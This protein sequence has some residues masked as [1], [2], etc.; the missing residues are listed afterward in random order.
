MGDLEALQ[1]AYRGLAKSLD[2]ERQSLSESRA[3][4]VALVQELS[5]LRIRDKQA[6]DLS[7]EKQQLQEELA[8]LKYSHDNLKSEV[9]K[10]RRQANEQHSLLEHKSFEIE[11][12]RKQIDNIQQLRDRE[13]A[14]WT[15]E[16][17]KVE[18]EAVELR[19]RLDWFQTTEQAFRRMMSLC[20]HIQE[21]LKVAILSG[22]GPAHPLRNSPLPPTHGCAREQGAA[23]TRPT[24]RS[25]GSGATWSRRAQPCCTAPSPSTRA[26]TTRRRTTPSSTSSTSI[27]PTWQCSTPTPT[28]SPSAFATTTE[29]CSSSAAPS[30]PPSPARPRPQTPRVPSRGATRSSSRRSCAAVASPPPPPPSPPV[31]IP[32]RCVL[33]LSFLVSAPHLSSLVTFSSSCAPQ[34]YLAPVAR[35][36]VP[37]A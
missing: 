16:F 29:R 14:R 26:G 12:L 8:R 13:G 21:A 25:S 33:R 24:R 36:C 31:V 6:T 28:S 7:A 27:R 37:P 5:A 17:A 32:R 22:C 20:T 2:V 35:H 15:E 3:Q 1:T 19:E 34:P 11:R 9:E 23:S 10:L 4:C 30:T 18:A